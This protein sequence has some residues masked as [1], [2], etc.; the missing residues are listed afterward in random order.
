MSDMRLDINQSNLQPI[1][2][3]SIL[4]LL[5][6]KEKFSGTIAIKEDGLLEIIEYKFQNGLAVTEELRMQMKCTCELHQLVWGGCICGAAEMENKERERKD[7]AQK[8]KEGLITD[9]DSVW[10][11]EQN[12]DIWDCIVPIKSPSICLGSGQLTYT[13]LQ[14]LNAGSGYYSWSIGTGVITTSNP[15][16]LVNQ[17]Y[18]IYGT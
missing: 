11:P 1:D 5:P 10:E 16:K 8:N 15:I 13:N 4:D 9:G 7:R 12:N 14:T 2:K 17:P 18:F 3:W 6:I